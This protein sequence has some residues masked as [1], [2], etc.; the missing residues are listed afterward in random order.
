MCVCVFFHVTANTYSILY[1]F[2][3]WEFWVWACL[4]TFLS[5][6]G[7]SIAPLGNSLLSFQLPSFYF[8]PLFLAFGAGASL[9]YN[10]SFQPSIQ[11]QWGNQ[12][13]QTEHQP[14]AFA[15]NVCR[16]NRN[17]TLSL[18]S[19]KKLSNWAQVC[20]EWL[21]GYNLCFALQLIDN[22]SSINVKQKVNG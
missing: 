20:S 8:L 11:R 2:A 15:I 5:T 22:I 13:Q 1:I 10:G 18:T 12:Q 16:M 19:C 6:Q 9:R 4:K 21:P 14:L 3:C 7:Y 17:G